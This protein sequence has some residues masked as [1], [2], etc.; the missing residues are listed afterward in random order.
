[1]IYR[2]L[3]GLYDLLAE[4]REC[5]VR[6]VLESMN[7]DVHDC[8]SNCTECKKKLEDHLYQL[9]KEAHRKASSESDKVE[10]I[11][12]EPKDSKLETL[13]RIEER[14]WYGET[15]TCDLVNELEKIGYKFDCDSCA[16]CK[17]A[18]SKFISKAIDELESN[19]GETVNHPAH[20]NQFKFECIDE[21][22]AVFGVE[23]V[24]AFCKCNAWKYRYRSNAKNGKEDQDKADWYLEKLM[25]LNE[26]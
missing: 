14:F 22:V 2:I 6:D 24:K 8:D 12:A 4:E 11:E 17:E 26:R 1:M 16:G 23:D 25:E 5:S 18:F 7:V 21:L 20:Y 13:K 10:L 9:R 3:D 15:D 19:A